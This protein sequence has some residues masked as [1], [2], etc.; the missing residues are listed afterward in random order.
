MTNNSAKTWVVIHDLHFP[1]VHWS[2]FNAALDFMKQNKVAGFVFGGD[3]FDNEEISHHNKAKPLFKPRASY[4]NNEHN[5]KHQIFV[6]LMRLIPESAPRVWIIGNHDRFEY[7][8]VE[9]HPEMEGTVERV[10][11]LE[12]ERYGWKVIELG[13]AFRIGKLNVI[14]GEILSGI[15]NQCG[16]YPAKKAVELY[17]ASV[18]AGHTHSPQSFAKISP[19]EHVQKHMGWIAPCCCTVNPTYLQNRPTAW[20]NGITIVEEMAGGMFN[21]FPCITLNGRFAYGGKV[22]GI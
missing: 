5:F 20:L 7:D 14:H 21:V 15:G 10:R 18:L 13:H 11:T 22:Y 4:R 6:E 2:T 17:G 8:L 16:L 3:Q 9:A 1:K 12:L 19:V